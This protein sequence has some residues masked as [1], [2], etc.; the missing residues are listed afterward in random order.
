MGNPTNLS[1]EGLRALVDLTRDAACLIEAIGKRVVYANSQLLRLAGLSD[2]ASRSIFLLI[3]D[4]DTPIIRELF[5]ELA[6]GKCAERRVEIGGEANIGSRRITGVRV[7]R[8][9]TDSGVLLAMVLETSTV[10]S[11]C[12]EKR[13]QAVDPLT[14]LADRT[15]L[16]E[17]LTFLVQGDRSS[18]PSYAVLFVDVDN[19]KQV[20]DRHGHL[21]GDG[22]LREVARRLAG[23]VRT[24]DLVARFG[25][26]EFV[27][28]LERVAGP[29]ELLPVLGRIAAAFVEPIPVGQGAV[30]LSVSV[31]TAL[32]DNDGS[33][34]EEL[35]H[36]ADR[37]MYATKKASV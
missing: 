30:T 3:P 21:V 14:G 26:D 37:A 33:S 5:S 17:K 2:V 9:E 20:N 7:R 15:Q 22:V 34:A 16:L 25:G 35:I 19:F 11:D 24:G 1:W 12:M 4:L 31:G 28:L 18:T 29:S 27:V 13:S 8:V 6:A 32:A 36:R 10:A 23:S